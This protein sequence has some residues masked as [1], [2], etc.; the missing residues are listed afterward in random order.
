MR[1][2]QRGNSPMLYIREKNKMRRQMPIL[3]LVALPFAGAFAQDSS[4][5][6]ASTLDVYAF[7][8]DGQSSEQQSKDESA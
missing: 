6:I 5:T 3:I 8:K 4:K 1:D 7:P 2:R